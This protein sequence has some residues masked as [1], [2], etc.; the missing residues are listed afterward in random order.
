MKRFWTVLLIVTVAIVMALPAGAVKPDNPGKPP[1]DEP[2]V[3]LTCAEAAIEYGID[4]VDGDWNDAMTEFTVKVGVREDACVDV[5]SLEGD[6]EIKVDIGTAIQVGF[7]VRDSFAGDRCWGPCLGTGLVTESGTYA[8]VTPASGLDACGDTFGDEDEALAFIAWA[9]FRGPAKSA[10]PAT[11][12]VTLP[13]E[14][15][16]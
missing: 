8:F 15:L 1:P 6:W 13:A 7:G 5:I 9:D 14:P 2:L 10:T 12:T 16:P 4:H 11:I 3:G